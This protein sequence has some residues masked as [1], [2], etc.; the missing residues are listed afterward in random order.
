VFQKT[1]DGVAMFIYETH[2]HTSIV[3]ACADISP[4]DQVRA[5]KGRGYTGVVITD[6]FSN[7]NSNCPH[8]L[9]WDKKIEFLASGYRKAKKEGDKCG[10]DVFFGWEYNI[11]GTEFLTYGLSI[12][13][14]LEHPGMEWLTAAQYSKL[15][16]G[17]GGYLAQAHPYRDGYWIDYP[18]PVDPG[19]IDG[20]EVYNSTMPDSINKKAHD[21]A[22]LHGLP[23]QAGSDSHSRH[24][25]FASGV[26]LDKKAESIFDIIEAIKTGQ[27]KLVGTQGDGSLVFL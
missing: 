22:R 9:P 15:I 25:P 4:A 26:A 19:L 27:A 2:M 3:S 20:I 6:H 24:N 10:L 1:R 7:G 23:M 14:L 12:D 13:F 21:F 16:R 18:Y 17:N 8:K 11:R 5:Y